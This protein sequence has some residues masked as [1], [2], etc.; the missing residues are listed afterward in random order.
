MR[1]F[2]TSFDERGG[3]HRNEAQAIEFCLD[4]VKLFNP[5]FT[6]NDIEIRTVS[7]SYEEFVGY[8]L[9]GHE[10]HNTYIRGTVCVIFY[11]D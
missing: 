1:I 7:I 10:L 6:K 5:H 2:E 9:E 3:S 8:D 4:G 11:E